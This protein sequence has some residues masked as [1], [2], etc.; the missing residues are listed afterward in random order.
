MRPMRL[1][2]RE[3]RETEELRWILEDC[4]VVRIGL[5]DEEGMFIVPVNFGYE[6]SEQDGEWKLTLYIHSAR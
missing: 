2:K 3:V 4:D 6:L 1:A 5:T